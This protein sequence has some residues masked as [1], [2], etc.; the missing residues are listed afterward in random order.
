M[1]AEAEFSANPESKNFEAHPDKHNGSWIMVRANKFNNWRF[2]GNILYYSKEFD[3]ELIDEILTT[4][5]E[6]PEME[7]LVFHGKLSFDHSDTGLTD[8]EMDSLDLIEE[9]LAIK[10]DFEGES[11]KSGG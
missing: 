5:R 11:P 1:S 8:V 3:P 2:E 10:E 9:Y 7:L 6:N 4:R